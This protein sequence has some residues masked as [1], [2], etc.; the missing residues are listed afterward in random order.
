MSIKV[1]DKIKFKQKTYSVPELAEKIGLDLTDMS[2]VLATLNIL[3]RQGKISIVD[4]STPEETMVE[5][6]IKQSV[7][8]DTIVGK[9]RAEEENEQLLRRKKKLDEVDHV[10][11]SLTFY[12]TLQAQKFNNW[13]NMNGI[14]TTKLNQ[15][16]E[17]GEIELIVKDI[18]PAEYTVISNKYT[19]ENV[20]NKTVDVADKTIKKTTDSVNY[21]ASE[22]VAPVAKIAGKGA[23][24]LAKGL[25]HTGV[26]VGA[27][28][29]NSGIQAVEETKIAMATDPEL[30][31]ASDQLLNAKN[32][33][34]RR[35]TKQKNKMGGSGIK[36]L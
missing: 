20:I 2:V 8:Q 22:V 32:A 5:D 31:K 6:A 33:I 4:N 1:N 12:Q 35:V 16:L 11:I 17:T 36:I 30:L 13:L 18:T 28:L 26:K 23:M 7:F 34:A 14:N 24:N 27:S 3:E 15:D 25:F 19:A 29:L 21:M 10:S 9:I